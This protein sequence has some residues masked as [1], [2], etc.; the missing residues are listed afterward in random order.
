MKADVPTDVEGL[1]RLMLAMAPQLER[2]QPG[3]TAQ[4]Q[5]YSF[6]EPMVMMAPSGEAVTVNFEPT[7]PTTAIKVEVRPPAKP[8][9]ALMARFWHWRTR[10]IVKLMLKRAKLEVERQNKRA[11][12]PEVLPPEK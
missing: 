8:K 12:E 6:R 2:R 3:I 10:W 11:L 9:G 7:G 4:L 5:Y 1:R